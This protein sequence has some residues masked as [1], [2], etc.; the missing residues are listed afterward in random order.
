MTF[1]YVSNSTYYFYNSVVPGNPPVNAC[2]LSRCDSIC[3]IVVVVT[4]IDYNQFTCKLL[5]HFR[6]GDFRLGKQLQY[7]VGSMC[8]ALVYPHI[9]IFSLTGMIVII[10]VFFTLF[11]FLKNELI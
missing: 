3:N 7:C 2:N 9:Y 5:V 10:C 4:T 8:L 1:I 6:L 11:H